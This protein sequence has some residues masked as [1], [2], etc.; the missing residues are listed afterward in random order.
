MA[1]VALVAPVAPVAPLDPVAPVTPLA[2][3]APLAPAA[4]LTPLAPLNPFFPATP[5]L[6]HEI[7]DSPFLH[8]G[9]FVNRRPAPFFLTHAYSVEAPTFG[10]ATNAVSSNSAPAASTPSPRRA[11]SVDIRSSGS[12]GLR[13]PSLREQLMTTVQA[14]PASRMR[15][16]SQRLPVASTGYSSIE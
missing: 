9:F 6:F 12:M 4:P 5:A 10:G 2:P 1:P 3:S 16:S 13:K 8:F 11:V 15:A 14:I 7:L